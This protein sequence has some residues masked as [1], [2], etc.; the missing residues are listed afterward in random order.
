[1]KASEE[2]DS[3]LDDPPLPRPTDATGIFDS[4]P[5]SRPQASL[6][7]GDFN[8]DAATGTFGGSSRTSHCQGLATGTVIAGRYTLIEVIGEGGMGSVYRASQVEPVKRQ[9]ALK[10]IKAGMDSRSVLARFDAERQAL[11]VM[12]HPGIARVFDGGRTVNGQAGAPDRD[13]ARLPLKEHLDRFESDLAAGLGTKGNQRRMPPS[14]AQVKLVVQ[15]V[16]HI[17]DG[18]GFTDPPDLNTDA[19]A[20]LARYLKGRLGKPV[21]R[22]SG[23]E[24]ES[25]LSAQSASF[26]LSAA[27]RFVRW[28]S[29]KAP[30]ASDLFDG[31]AGFAPQNDRRHARR[32]VSPEEL[33]RLIEAA[34]DS[35]T[36][37]REL[38]GPDRAML[39]LTAFATGYRVA[40]LA[41][42]TPEC[43]DLDAEPPVAML[44]G[45]MT[46]NKKR[47]RQPLPPGVAYQLRA[48]L[49]NKPAGKPVWPG[50]WS[51]RAVSVLRRD[52]AAA[53]V[54]YKITTIDG[55]RYADFHAL[56]HSYLSALAAA[57]V[58]VKE[59][60]E[61]AR[62]SDPRITLGIYTHARAESLGG[63][64]ARLQLPGTADENPLAKLTRAEL[65]KM[66]GQLQAR[67]AE[68]E[69][70]GR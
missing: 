42:L 38:T 58:G 40:E 29:K 51:E 17:L 52:L 57:G 4:E 49:A 56:R 22:E 61:L 14:E 44:P 62:H 43:F 16:R 41:A 3:L 35:V 19:P 64:V 11:A 47:A 18:C 39:Y 5:E 60:Q 26:Y 46:K 69:G 68:L 25:G 36:V 50:T 15:R 30:I 28:L 13:A 1:L 53:N 45:R 65:E 27:R 34:R 21:L 66:V 6:P 10:L 2:P 8:P 20:K 31:L 24:A 67:V 33:A 37:I 70:R 9:V 54:P 48:F 23:R 63:A 32:E 55:D 59:L 7:T 12:D